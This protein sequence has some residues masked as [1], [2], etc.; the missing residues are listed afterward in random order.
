VDSR[1][2]AVLAAVGIV[3]V[4][5]AVAFSKYEA[6]KS[7]SE[8]PPPSRAFDGLSTRGDASFVPA[9]EAAEEGLELALGLRPRK[10][11]RELTLTLGAGSALLVLED[12]RDRGSTDLPMAFGDGT[13]TAANRDAGTAFVTAVAKWL[14]V[15]IPPARLDPTPLEPIRI[16]YVRLGTTEGGKPEALKLFLQSRKL[17]AEVY[18]NLM[19][20]GSRATLLEKDE[21]Y[22]KDLIAFLAMA[23]RDGP[24][25]RRSANNDPQLISDEPLIAE[26]VPL[27]GKAGRFRFS[28]DGKL[29]AAREGSLLRFTDPNEEPEVLAKL[30]AEV[31]DVLPAPRGGL[32]ALTLIETK[33]PGS[34]AS[35]D[36]EWVVLWDAKTRAIRQVVSRKVGGTAG[37]W[38]PD[39]KQ[40]VIVQRTK[41]RPL[42]NL[43]RV[44]DVAA[45]EL[46]PGTDPA[47]DVRFAAWQAN[48]ILLH[49]PDWAT[50]D[51]AD[52]HFYLWQGSQTPPKMVPRPT[53]SSTSPD[54]RF[55]VVV[56]RDSISVLQKT[57]ATK[58]YRPKREEDRDALALLREQPPV[59]IGAHAISFPAEEPFVLD[60]ESLRLQR[61]SPRQDLTPEVVSADGRRIVLRGPHGETFHAEVR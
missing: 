55:Q 21:D 8:P 43:V 9:Q 53:P 14:N 38:S 44:Y 25:L 39:A 30:D 29:L 24:P 20:D 42:H 7:A 37:G 23:L 28:A 10:G 33:S 60:L 27:P 48:G 32:V 5:V 41:Q 31:F 3:A 19:S 47:F 26:V 51:H 17:D 15:P 46:G 58:W 36:P 2:A 45:T 4:A 13:I 6:R 12:A 18:L 50:D 49:H 16:S 56:G 52:E 54:G 11:A 22:R 35:D 61:L 1:S 59:F 57:A 34:Y 40:L